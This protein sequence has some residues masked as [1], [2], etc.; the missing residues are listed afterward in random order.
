M[1]NIFTEKNLMASSGIPALLVSLALAATPPGLV[2]TIIDPAGHP[3]AKVAVTLKHKGS[4]TVTDNTGKFRFNDPGFPSSR[5]IPAESLFQ[6]SKQALAFHV[7][8][9]HAWVRLTVH[10]FSGREMLRPLDTLLVR[11]LYSIYPLAS[12][13]FRLAAGIY[14]IRLK[15]DDQTYEHRIPMN[16]DNKFRQG[17]TFHALPTVE[18]AKISGAGLD[19]LMVSLPGRIAKQKEI[20]VYA[21]SLAEIVLYPNRVGPWQ[22]DD[23]PY[24]KAVAPDVKIL[25]LLTTGEDMPY[26]GDSSRSFRMG[27]VPDGLGLASVDAKH[28]RLFMN[29]EIGSTDSVH[30]VTP[31]PTHKGAYV[32]EFLLE[33]P[34]GRI[35]SGKPAFSETQLN[36][37][38]FKMQGSFER[39]CSGFLG[40]PAE[41]LT[42]PIY[43]TG[44]ETSE[45]GRS[46]TKQ[47]PQAVAIHGGVAFMLPDFGKMAFENIVVVPT[48]KPSRTVAF[49]LE[50]GPSQG[51]QLY[52][53]VGEK[54]NDTRAPHVVLQNGLMGGKLYVFS[55]AGGQDEGTFKS[56]TRK[57]RWADPLLGRK[58]PSRGMLDVARDTL[59]RWSRVSADGKD[60]SFNFDRIEDGTYDRET[61]GVFYFVTT[62]DPAAARNRYGRIYKLTFDPTDPV[63]GKPPALE[64]LAQGDSAA[65]FVSPDNIDIGPGRKMV[66]CEDFNLAMPRPPAV[67]MLDL[68]SKGLRKLAEVDVS[69]VP[70]ESRPTGLK[71]VWETSGVIDASSQLGAG[72]WLINVQPHSVSGAAAASWQGVPADRSLVQGG[73]LLMLHVSP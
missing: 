7:L 56:G 13:R 9:S 33:K 22:T 47:G 44:E 49:A 17:L 50:D 46:F 59:D 57:G 6:V 41:G 55:A 37:Y 31:G 67:W 64:I 25:P 54:S 61:Q 15:I 1:K 42:T 73:Q 63:G 8:A 20:L 5:N 39:L 48:R 4:A 34:S 38:G 19:T 52:M 32:S 26:T 23:P 71:T 14:D 30:A 28:A 45:D 65:G 16:R 40:G 72:S 29:H 66:I 35:L 10:D 21:D 18:L 12:Q 58:L 51:S 3:L 36:A 24:L 60:S 43:F 27:G 69:A 68:K 2:G 11:G 70:A 62:G 53:Y